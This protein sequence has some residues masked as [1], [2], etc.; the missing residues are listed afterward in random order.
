MYGSRT[1]PG[2][3]HVW[4]ADQSAGNGVGVFTGPQRRRASTGWMRAARQ[5]G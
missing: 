5:A 4:K 1:R 3:N 2:N